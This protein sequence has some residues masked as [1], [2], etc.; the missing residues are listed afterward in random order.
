MEYEHE[1]GNTG[2]KIGNTNMEKLKLGTGTC[3]TEIGNMKNILGVLK[4]SPLAPLGLCRMS[5]TFWGS[6]H[7]LPSL[8]SAY[9]ELYH[10]Y[11]FPFGLADMSSHVFVLLALHCIIPYN[12]V[13]MYSVL[14]NIQSCQLPIA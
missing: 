5:K 3:Q 7:F 6:S 11:T 4:C 1:T 14:I 10:A 8:R 12:H 13:S 2:N 9:V